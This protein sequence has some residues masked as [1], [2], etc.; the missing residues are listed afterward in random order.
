MKKNFPPEI[1]IQL[2]VELIQ[3]FLAGREGHWRF[4]ENCEVI[5][6]PP[7]GNISISYEKYQEL[8]RIITHH[9]NM[10]VQDS[11]FEAFKTEP[12]EQKTICD[13]EEGVHKKCRHD[14]WCPNCDLRISDCKCKK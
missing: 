8:K 2:T 13:D 5:I 7:Q 1:K 14:F 6:Y 9:G 12:W 3:A 4:G 11:F 10:L